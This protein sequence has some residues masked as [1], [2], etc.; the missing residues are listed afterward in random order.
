MTR[1][2]YVVCKGERGEGQVPDVA[3]AT[4]DAALDVLQRHLPGAELQIRNTGWTWMATL[5]GVDEMWIY[6][7]VVPHD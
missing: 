6:R 2:V 7:M 1:H 3:R 4:F 5:N